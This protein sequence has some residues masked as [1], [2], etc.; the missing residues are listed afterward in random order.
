MRTELRTLGIV[1]LATV[2]LAGCG[3]NDNSVFIDDNGND[4]TSS[5][6]ATPARTTTPALTPTGGVTPQATVT[7]VPTEV[8]A[9]DTP[10]PEETETPVPTGPTSTP[11]GPTARRSRLGWS[12]T[13]RQEAR[14]CPSSSCPRSDCAVSAR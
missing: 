6:T 5:R 11:V 10:I 14:P 12:D 2:L 1:V 9:T 4:N 7:E 13:H 8:V 3:D